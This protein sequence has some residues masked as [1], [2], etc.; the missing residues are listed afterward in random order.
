MSKIL[1]ISAGVRLPDDFT[2]NH[3]EGL[4]FLLYEFMRQEELKRS[5][6]NQPLDSE[7]WVQANET[8]IWYQIS[9]VNE[10]SITEEDQEAEDGEIDAILQSSGRS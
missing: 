7:V 8:D 9:L 3:A 10:C 1:N 5:Q 2:G 4:S 6:G